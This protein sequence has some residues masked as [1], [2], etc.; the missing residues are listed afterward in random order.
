[1]IKAQLNGDGLSE[2]E[3]RAALLTAEGNHYPNLLTQSLR[4]AAVLVPLMAINGQW[5]MLF[6]HRT[7]TVE[8]HKG[9]VS[10]PG[11][12]ADLDDKNAIGTALRE[13][14]EEVGIL[15]ADVNILGCLEPIATVSNYLI[16]PVVGTFPWPYH[17][18]PS[19]YEVERIFSIPL[20][21]LKTPDHWEEKIYKHPG[22]GEGMVVFY[23]PYDGEILWGITARIAVSLLQI[24]GI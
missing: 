13:A 22:G 2:E 10:F 1:M 15:P 6:I 21:W 16:T 18:K 9:Q 4:S 20:S 19:V 7:E 17:L 3:I 11:G 12:V 24:I 5:H 14:F 23:Q 8:D